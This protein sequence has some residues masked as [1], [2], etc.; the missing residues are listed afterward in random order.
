MPWIRPMYLHP[1]HVNDRLV[2]TWAR[3]RVVPYLDM[4]VQH[5]DDG[6]L[7]GDAA[8]RDRARA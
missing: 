3:A 5:A 4:P 7:E 2:E 6:D 8:R 1:A